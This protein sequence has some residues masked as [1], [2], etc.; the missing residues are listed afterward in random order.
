MLGKIIETMF[1]PPLSNVGYFDGQEMRI[2][3]RRR[4]FANGMG[5][6]PDGKIV[7]DPD[8]TVRLLN[9]N[10]QRCTLRT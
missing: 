8:A 5:Q 9:D 2:V 7:R 1:M 3:E 4:V 10:Y 6:S